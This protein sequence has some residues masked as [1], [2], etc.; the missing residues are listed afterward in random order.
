MSEPVFARSDGTPFDSAERRY[1]HVIWDWNG[2][3]LDDVDFSVELI[4]R[5]LDEGGF[6]R[7][8]LARYRAIFDFPIR[9]YYERA[10][11]DLSSDGA[12]E[13]LGRAWMDAY[14]LGRLGCPLHEGAR[15]ILAAIQEAKVT[16]SILSAYPRSNLETIVGHF[17]LREH[18]VRVLG[19]DDI[20][21][22]SKIEL[23]RRWLGE[24]GL[25]PSRILLVGDTLHDLEVAHALGSDCTLV[26]AGHQSAQ[27][28]RQATPRVL[29]SLSD[30]RPVLGLRSTVG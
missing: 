23:G 8:D 19:L 5:L 24:L 1:D 15:E 30:L 20:W 22:R 25:P 9:L 12:F 16:Q 11:F 27:R 26:A 7:M 2:T 29:D 18:F 10:G 6:P 17:G 13:R 28:L 21:A 4:N 3:L 14:E